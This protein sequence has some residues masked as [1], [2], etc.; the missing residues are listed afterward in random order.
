[1]ATERID[2]LATLFAAIAVLDSHQCHIS[3]EAIREVRSAVAELIEAAFAYE[4]GEYWDGETEFRT[5]YNT[6]RRIEAD[7]LRAALARVGGAS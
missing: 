6:R 2:V 7:R 5:D 1:M 4:R 3:S